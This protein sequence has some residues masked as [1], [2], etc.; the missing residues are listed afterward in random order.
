MF[1]AP[2]GRSGTGSISLGSAVTRTDGGFSV[3]LPVP[4]SLDLARYEIL[5]STADDAYYNA[6]LSE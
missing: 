5:L 3:D 2:A 6:A 1:L 4:G